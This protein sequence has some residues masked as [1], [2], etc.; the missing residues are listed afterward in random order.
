METMNN[1]VAK[2]AGKITDEYREYHSTLGE[3]FLSTKV[4]VV[5]KSGGV[6][7]LPVVVSEKLLTNEIKSSDF[8]SFEGQIRTFNK[9]NG[10]VE[11]YLFARDCELA[12]EGTYV[13]DVKLRGFLCK[14]GKF[15]T[16]FTERKVIDFILAVNRQFNKSDYLPVLAWGKDARYVSGKEV[17]EE[18]EISGR[19]QSRNYTK[20]DNEGNK[21]E[22][23]A[24]EV[25]SS[26]VIALN[27]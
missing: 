9:P 3:D 16:T 8:V 22:G 10:S 18:F 12:E 4:E 21:T 1:N 25:S 23:V 7:V 17:S 5:R 20:K 24:Y 13:N 2:I 26:Q 15:R 27:K 6:D 19:F 14:K 11:T